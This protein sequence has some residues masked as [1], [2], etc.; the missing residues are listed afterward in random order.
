[1]LCRLHDK[2]GDGGERNTLQPH[3]CNNEN[4]TGE[5]TWRLALSLQIL[6]FSLCPLVALVPPLP[7]GVLIP[8]SPAITTTWCEEK[9]PD[10]EDGRQNFFARRSLSLAFLYIVQT[11]EA[12]FGGCAFRTHLPFLLTALLFLR[13]HSLW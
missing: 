2:S 13:C 3:H 11:N 5:I 4:N 1:M 12:D 7:F 10:D 9:K 8:P 6:L